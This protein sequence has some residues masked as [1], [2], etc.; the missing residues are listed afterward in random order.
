[1]SEKQYVHVVDV[2]GD[3][4]RFTRH[5]IERALAE[6]NRPPLRGGDIVRLLN[7]QIP[8]KDER[9]IVVEEGVAQTLR[10]AQPLIG[11]GHLVVIGLKDGDVYS[12]RAVWYERVAK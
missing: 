1:M 11:A 12:G 7:P 5:A 6:L 2:N 9:F 8:G 3:S 4:R 10:A